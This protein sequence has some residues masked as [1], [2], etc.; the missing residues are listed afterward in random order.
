MNMLVQAY[1]G[2][3]MIS[4]IQSLMMYSRFYSFINVLHHLYVKRYEVW[5]IKLPHSLISHLWLW[6][7]FVVPGC[8]KPHLTHA[9]LGVRHILVCCQHLP[10]LWS[11]FSTYISCFTIC[12]IFVCDIVSFSC[13]TFCSTCY[14]TPYVAY[15]LIVRWLFFVGF[16]IAL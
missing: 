8:C 5:N 9:N 4:F 12:F 6:Q 11:C 15:A 13:M 14:N 2:L 1:L 3:L 16:Y 10:G 7:C